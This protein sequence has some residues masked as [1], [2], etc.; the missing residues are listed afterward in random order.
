[1]QSL[2]GS[3]LD[4]ILETETTQVADDPYQAATDIAIELEQA[5]RRVTELERELLYATDRLCGGLAMGVRKAQP[6]LNVGLDK[7]GCKVGYKTKHLT[8]RPDLT[9]RIW[10]IDSGDPRFARRFMHGNRAHMALNS[11]LTGLAKSVADFFTGY[12]L[13]LGEAIEGRGIILLGGEH[14]GMA[15]LADFVRQREKLL[16][17][18]RG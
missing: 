2:L 6:G 11:D 4:L 14:V 12:Y 15:D 13:T 17:E 8:M 10:I 5:R 16:M 18:Y 1:M 7:G 9:K 3:R